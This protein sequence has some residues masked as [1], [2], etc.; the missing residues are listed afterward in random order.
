[1]SSTAV[2]AMQNTD[3]ERA[4]GKESWWSVPD[5]QKR[6]EGAA[7]DTWKITQKRIRHVYNEY[8]KQRPGSKQPFTVGGRHDDEVYVVEELGFCFKVIARRDKQII[9]SVLDFVFIVVDGECDCDEDDDQCPIPAGHD[10]EFS[11]SN[12]F[13]IKTAAPFRVTNG[14]STYVLN[15]DSDDTLQFQ[16]IANPES[17]QGTHFEVVPNHVC[18]D[19]QGSDEKGAT[20]VSLRSVVRKPSDW[21][22]AYNEAAAGRQGKFMVE[23][24]QK[25]ECSP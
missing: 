13:Y 19:L 22:L 16:D 24:L 1:M 12:L 6:L 25:V 10:P 18:E 11:H 4:E 15:A 5:Y 21:F 20:I 7:K 17:Y 9:R 23:E 3:R 14:A 8:K 2:A